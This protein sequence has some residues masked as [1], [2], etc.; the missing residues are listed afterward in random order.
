MVAGSHLEFDM[1]LWLPIEA[2]LDNTS[3]TICKRGFC[4]HHTLLYWFHTLAFFRPLAVVP[5][6]LGDSGIEMRWRP[7]VE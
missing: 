2:L 3:L 4:P 1:Y 5:N 7:C 6:A